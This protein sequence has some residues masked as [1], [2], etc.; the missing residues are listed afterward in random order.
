[1]IVG[2]FGTEGVISV[3]LPRL[4]NRFFFARGGVKCNFLPGELGCIYTKMF[5]DKVSIA[6]RRQNTITLSLIS[7]IEGSHSLIKF[8]TSKSFHFL[9]VS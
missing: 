6:D 4:W 9:L 8:A 2:I 7:L 3:S 5:K 1:M